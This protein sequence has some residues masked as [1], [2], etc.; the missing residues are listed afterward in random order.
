MHK[1]HKYYLLKYSYIARVFKG[2]GRIMSAELLNL[3]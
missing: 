3:I 2:N 1:F